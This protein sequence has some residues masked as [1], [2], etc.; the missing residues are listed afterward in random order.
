[1]KRLDWLLENGRLIAETRTPVELRGWWLYTMLHGLHP[2]REKL[3]LFWHDHFATSINKVGSAPLM[4]QQNVTLREHALGKFEPFLQA[5]SK[6]PAMLVW[7]D[8]GSNVKGK[9]NE[10]YAR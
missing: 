8:A 5:M 1:V 9:A 4:L 7:L 10:N 3:T 2:L 6:D